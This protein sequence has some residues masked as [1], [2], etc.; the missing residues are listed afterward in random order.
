MTCRVALVFFALFLAGWTGTAAAGTTAASEM[1]LP[2]ALAEAYQKNP[3]LEAV[4]AELKSVD[5]NYAQAV[6]GF[7]PSV[8]GTV[9]YTSNHNTLGSGGTVNSDPKNLSL[10]V[11]QSLYS[12][13]STMADVDQ[14]DSKIKAERAKLKV[15]EQT[16]LRNAVAAYMNL[17]RDQEIVQLRM[18]NESVLTNHLDASNARFKL[19]DITR[20]DV[21]QSESRLAKALASRIA[22]EGDLKKSRAVFEQVIGSPAS[23]LKKPD[24]NL[25]LPT[26]EDAALEIALRNNPS[27]A[28]AKYTEDAAHAAIRSVEGGNLPKIDLT[29]TIGKIYDPASVAARDEDTQ[30]IEIKATIPLYAGGSTTSKVRQARQVENQRRMETQSA[31]RAVHRSVV[32]AWEAL[33]AAEAESRALQTQIDAAKLALDGVK[34]EQEYG[35]RTT[36]DLLDAEQE[37]LDAQVAHV[38]AETDRIVA[39]YGL[40]A[41]V[42]ALT[43]QN[44]RLDVPVY[45]PA[46]NFQNDSVNKMYWPFHRDK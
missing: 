28:M 1:T 10:Q 36:L 35:S 37:Y 9:D 7:R 8:N 33:V 5:E 38:S 39:S 23:S 17:I 19:G 30:A 26:T 27:I 41:A 20:T 46:Q 12:G 31:E 44:L 15:T 24:V 32:E 29:G 45:D 22:A 18:K 34:V 6:A 43:A 2:A 42:G 11:T 21:S 40:L 3:D 4:R 14:S 16:V 13:G 25:V